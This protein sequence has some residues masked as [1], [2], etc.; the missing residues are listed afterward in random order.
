MMLQGQWNIPQWATR[1]P[2][3]TFDVAFQP[4]S[5]PGTQGRLSYGPGGANQRFV[6]A[7][8]QL[9]AVAGDIL[10][11]LGSVEGQ[12]AWGKHTQGSDP[13]LFQVAREASASDPR[14]QRVNELTAQW[15]VLGP[16]PAVRNPGVAQVNLEIRPLTP[17]L[18]EV[19][20][21]LFTG[22]LS[23]IGAALQDLQD[24]ANAE[25]DRAIEAAREMGAEVSRDDWVFP[26]WNPAADYTNDMY[27]EL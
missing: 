17:N 14:M 13:P 12:I 4:L 16:S 2:D 22:Q 8:S 27:Q 3:F 15:M 11:Y 23:D 1:N 25:L 10:H 24:R 21:G 19:V 9:L 20:Q 6:S 26:N 18:G 7:S 5:D